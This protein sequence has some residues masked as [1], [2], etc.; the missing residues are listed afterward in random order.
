MAYHVDINKLTVQHMIDLA[1]KP[2]IR[3]LAAILADVTGAG[4]AI[5]KLSIIEWLPLQAELA[6]ALDQAIK[7][8]VGRDFAAIFTRR[9]RGEQDD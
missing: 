8:Q 5:Y 6:A 7:G 9:L 4:K 1:E 2:D 3:T